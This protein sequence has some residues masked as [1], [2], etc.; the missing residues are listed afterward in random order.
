LIKLGA[1]LVVAPFLFVFSSLLHVDKFNSCAYNI[2]TVDYEDYEWDEEKAEENL[3]RHG[4]DF[5]D[6]VGVLEDPLALTIEDPDSHDEQRFISLG[7]DFLGRILKV[8]WTFRSKKY[9]LISAWPSTKKEIR[10]Y[11]G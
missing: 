11:E 6:A 7:M 8:V 10:D 9:R 4:V 1:P 2:C 3:K 5:A